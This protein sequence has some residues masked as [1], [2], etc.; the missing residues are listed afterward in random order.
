MTVLGWTLIGVSWLVLGRYAL[1]WLRWTL[2]LPI[3]GRAQDVRAICR[4]QSSW[5]VDAAVVDALK[6]A[7]LKTA[8]RSEGAGAEPVYVTKSRDVCD[9]RFEL[10]IERW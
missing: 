2:R 7:R 6:S 5:D 9:D 10:E 1:K 8:A 4:R 3:P